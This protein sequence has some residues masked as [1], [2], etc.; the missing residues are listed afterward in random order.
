MTYSP[1]LRSR[2]VLVCFLF[3]TLVLIAKIFL[4]QIVHGDDYSGSADRQYVTPADNIYERG[5]IFFQ[6]KNGQLISAATQTTGFK[7]AIDPSKITDAESVYIKLSKITTLDHDDFLLRAGK[8]ADSY[9][10]IMH[11]L[12]KEEADAISI[13]KIPGVNIFKEKWRLY[14]GGSLAS[15]TLGIVG[16]KGTE[17]GGRY[18]LERQYNTELTWTNNNPYVNFFAEVFSN[19]NKTLFESDKGEGN[20]VTTI[21]PEVQNFLE[22]KLT[23]V[24]GRYQADSIGGIIMNPMDGSIYAL[25]VKPDFDP[26]DFSKVKKISTF[27]NP[28]VENVLEFGSVVKPLVMAG[29]LD[30]GVLTADTTYNDKGS[31]IVEKKEI[32]NFDKKGRGPDTSMQEVLNQS[33]NTG[34]V[35][36]EQKLGKEKLR[37]YLLS[38]GIKDKTGIDLPNE[39]SGLV[40]NLNVT[41]EFEY[42]NA[43]FGQGIAI[44]PVSLVRALA[45]L[46]NGGNLVVPH[47]TKEIRYENGSS[48]KIVYP[49]TRAKIS[50]QT[51]EEI[52]RML[53]VVMDKSINKTGL[54]KLEHFSVAVKTGTAQVADNTTGGYYEDRHTHSFFGYFPAY[55]PKFII[56]LYAINPKG[57]QYAATTWTDPFLDITKFLLNYYE[58]PPDR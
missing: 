21:E 24:E 43:A 10:E 48:K 36:V 37:D 49:T 3:F 17:L 46:G 56:F 25:T 9:E 29:A 8:A 26:N 58:I 54:A 33:L 7:L 30:A 40:S 13:L 12:S 38:Y 31:V 41:R 44:T 18:G 20:I 53:V 16:Y 28:L 35:F 2:I 1:T 47:V 52:T 39:T 45:S 57:V 5:T 23:E 32:F 11:R 6:S 51:S 34:M 4:V 15:H 19:I 27:S 14:P 42:A 22:K 55:E 50:K